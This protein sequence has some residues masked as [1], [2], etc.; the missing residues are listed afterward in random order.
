MEQ[1]SVR[2]GLDQYAKACGARDEG[3]DLA[4]AHGLHHL[5]H[6]PVDLLGQRHLLAVG[7]EQQRWL[8]VMLQE[9]AQV[10]QGGKVGLSSLGVGLL[11]EPDVIG[12]GH[13]GAPGRR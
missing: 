7:A 3:D 9:P 8:G 5:D 6:D 2:T 1:T 4:L 13:R 12:L 10:K 11:E